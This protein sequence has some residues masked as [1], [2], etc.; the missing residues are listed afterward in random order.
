VGQ[1]NWARVEVERR[2]L[3]EL[4]RA[5]ANV[6][7]EVAPAMAERAS[8]RSP[9]NNVIREQSF[10]CPS[11]VKCPQCNAMVLPKRLAKHRRKVHGVRD[12]L[13]PG[14]KH[15]RSSTVLEYLTVGPASFPVR[16]TQHEAQQLES[17]C[18]RQRV[19]PTALLTSIVRSWLQR[20]AGEVRS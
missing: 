2:E 1:M 14:P 8:A 19:T 17:V 11:K 4:K 9:S 18:A 5:P 20:Q 13:G 16:L 7:Q 12:S 15:E 3:R 6:E 10:S